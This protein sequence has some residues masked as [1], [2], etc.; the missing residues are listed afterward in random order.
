MSE[1]PRFFMLLCSVIYNPLDMTYRQSMIIPSVDSFK[2]REKTLLFATT[3]F[4]D[5]YKWKMTLGALR[6][7]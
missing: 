6:S 2:L 5:I 1:R 7:F 4:C 3:V